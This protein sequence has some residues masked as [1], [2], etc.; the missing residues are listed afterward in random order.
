MNSVSPPRSARSTA[1]RWH[2]PSLGLPFV[3]LLLVGFAALLTLVFVSR[4]PV[5]LWEDG[6]F[7]KRFAYNFW[8]HGSFSWNRTDG[9]IYGMTSQ[10]LQLLG[11]ALYVAA[12][13]HYV[14]NLKAALTAAPLF[15]LPLLWWLA[16]PLQDPARAPEDR[17]ALLPWVV[18]LALVPVLE[19]MLLGLESTLS[20][21]VVTLS[22]ALV[23][24]P[25]RG[26]WDLVWIVLSIL[27]VYA[28]RPDAVL[29][30]LCVLGGLWLLEL[31]RGRTTPLAE[32][33]ARALPLSAALFG[34]VAGLAVLLTAFHH[35]YG[36]ALPLPFYV[37]TMGITVQPEEYL[38]FFRVEKTENALR[39]AF[40][41]FPFVYIAL[42]ARTRSVLL[43]LT[44]AGVFCAYHYAATIE[45]MGYF[46]RFYLPA[47]APILA[48]AGLGQRS[49]QEQRR[50]WLSACVFALYC[51]VFV[52]FT[53]IDT[54]LHIRIMPEPTHYLP[55]IAASGVLLLGPARFNPVNALA[56][57]AC[58]LVG[59]A[60]QYPVSSLKIED[61]E[62][63]LL[64]QIAPRNVF[65]GLEQLREKLK[66]SVIYH[67][68]MGAP[69]MLFPE[70]K[71]VDLDGLLNEDITL[72]GKHFEEL[73]NAD[74]PEAI[75]VPNAGYERLR[76]EILESQ[77][78]QG[79]EAVTSG[80]APLH[81]RRDLLGR[82]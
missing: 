5:G 12:P 62:T 21:P 39:M 35:Y 6:Y 52:A 23:L 50:W 4:L 15:T 22:L 56:L 16:A 54:T 57:L 64:R 70:A 78:I 32:R 58:L 14:V 1:W 7:G 29:I 79:Y 31:T 44:A 2:T 63:I 28:T 71:V 38:D 13:H 51:G 66:P 53:Y 73:C 10:T 27:G 24:R 72:H 19:L 3:A 47:L 25:R 69:G 11:T 8:E 40:L 76:N 42:H 37:K 33:W 65:R 75:F 60:V 81:I 36:T 55:A 48:A 17:V 30:P 80:S 82:Y 68:D 43:L 20:L 49:Y 26:R 46:S 41:C 45:I 74:Q 34:V 61:D 59:G 18:G 9:P 67:T 77:C